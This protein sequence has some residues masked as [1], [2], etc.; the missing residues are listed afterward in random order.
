VIHELGPAQQPRVEVDP[1]YLLQE[2]QQPIEQIPTR[3]LELFWLR[4]KHLI[5]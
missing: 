3:A 5:V 1:G 4:L 2:S